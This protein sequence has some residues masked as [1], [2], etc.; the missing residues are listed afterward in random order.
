[1]IAK[2]VVVATRT[3]GRGCLLRHAM[4][5]PGNLTRLAPGAFGILPISVRLDRHSPATGAH[6]RPPH[7][8][9]RHLRHALFRNPTKDF[10]RPTRTWDFEEV[11]GPRG[12]VG[13]A[14]TS[15]L[16][17]ATRYTDA[18]GKGHR[19]RRTCI[20]RG[21]GVATAVWVCVPDMGCAAPDFPR[22][23]GRWAYA[24]TNRGGMHACWSRP[25]T[26]TMLLGAAR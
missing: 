1:M 17:G 16:W 24:S 26:T 20:K 7:S 19:R 3:R 15:R 8:K 18:F 6:P 12:I 23:V 21:R 2:G 14:V 25:V 10:S 9:D 5:I 11:P 4:T 13:G 22:N